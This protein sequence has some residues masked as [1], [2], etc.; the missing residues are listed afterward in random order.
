LARGGRA[1][2]DCDV[3]N[4]L[5]AVVGPLLVAWQLQGEADEN[6]LPDRG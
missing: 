6:G 5:P 3:I 4:G 2:G 1:E